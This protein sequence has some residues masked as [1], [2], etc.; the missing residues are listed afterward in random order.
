M[1][2]REFLAALGAQAIWLGMAERA[3]GMGENPKIP[4][5]DQGP[6]TLVEFNLTEVDGG[7]RL[8]VHE[9]GFAALSEERYVAAFA[10]NNG[11]W[12]WCVNSLTEYLE[13]P[14]GR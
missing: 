3:R 13:G 7:T 9:S 11:G 14:D 12:D 5:E 2:R 4:L 10:D 1:R 8:N 6:L